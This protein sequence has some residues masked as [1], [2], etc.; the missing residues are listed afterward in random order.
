MKAEQSI[1]AGF[2]NADRSVVTN[3]IKRELCSWNQKILDRRKRSEL[4]F[5][6]RHPSFGG[7]SESK[8][9]LLANR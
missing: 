1:R 7:F 5:P 3:V 9:A 4:R 6:R 8:K 2:G